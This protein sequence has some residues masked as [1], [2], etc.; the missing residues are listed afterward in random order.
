MSSQASATEAPSTNEG[1]LQ[2]SQEA[3]E[4][5]LGS[6]GRARKIYIQGQMYLNPLL[7]YAHTGIH[8]CVHTLESA[9]R[10]EVNVQL[11][12]AYDPTAE[13]EDGCTWKDIEGKEGRLGDRTVERRRVSSSP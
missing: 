8:L 10:D 12:A 1:Q 6:T 3:K 9:P 2:T 13:S 5:F 11:I 4:S 7:L